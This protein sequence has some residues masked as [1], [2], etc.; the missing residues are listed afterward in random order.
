MSNDH[1]SLENRIQE[2]LDGVLDDDQHEELIQRVES[3]AVARRLYLNQIATHT[4]L[5]AVLADCLPRSGGVH[6]QDGN[7]Q[8]AV[9]LKSRSSVIAVI[10]SLVVIILLLLGSISSFGPREP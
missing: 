5:Q 3:D 1:R 7:T 6:T 9:V 8:S 2:M 10:G 4:A